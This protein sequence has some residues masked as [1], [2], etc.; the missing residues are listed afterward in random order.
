M[1]SRVSP[2]V[3]VGLSFCFVTLNTNVNSFLWNLI[4]TDLYGRIVQQHPC[5]KCKCYSQSYCNYIKI[6]W[7]YKL[8]DNV[9]LQSELSFVHITEEF[10][11]FP[12]EYVLKIISAYILT[13][14]SEFTIKQGIL[15]NCT[16]SSILV[17]VY[18][19][20]LYMPVVW[21]PWRQQKICLIIKKK[22]NVFK[23]TKH[24]LKNLTLLL[25]SLTYACSSWGHNFCVVDKQ[26]L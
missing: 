4:S 21:I 5:S 13:I 20:T 17:N 24:Y 19:I 2:W 8:H 9:H 7:M 6:L 12:M 23:K 26:V 14:M 25:R 3:R 18:T 16:L 15:L 1:Y 11:K 10:C 22:K